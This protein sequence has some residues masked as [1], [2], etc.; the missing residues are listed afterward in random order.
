MKSEECSL[1]VLTLRVQRE[2]LQIEL[3]TDGKGGGGA[4]VIGDL[5]LSVDGYCCT[6]TSLRC[7]QMGGQD[8]LC[9][10]RNRHSQC[11]S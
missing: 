2:Q 3:F 8:A 7:S 9:S 11:Q 5:R 1:P 4:Q 6:D 10:N